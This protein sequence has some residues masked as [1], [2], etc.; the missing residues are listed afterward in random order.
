MTVVALLADTATL[1][2]EG[3]RLYRRHAGALLRFTF[4]PALTMALMV[5]GAVVYGET[6]RRA[7]P[8][9]G[10]FVA[11][12]LVCFPLLL[13]VT[14][15]VLRGV[16]TDQSLQARHLAAVGFYRFGRSLVLAVVV[17]PP[18]LVLGVVVARV[19]NPIVERNLGELR[20]W[21][22]FGLGMP[23]TFARFCIEV[24]ST[25]ETATTFTISTLALLLPYAAMLYLL[26]HRFRRLP[27]QSGAGW[28][29][30]TR[31][32][33]HTAIGTLL[34]NSVG[35]CILFSIASLMRYLSPPEEVGFAALFVLLLLWLWLLSPPLPILIALLYRRNRAALGDD[36]ERRVQEWA[37]TE[38]QQ[39]A[40]RQQPLAAEG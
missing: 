35:F 16:E 25:I 14:L 13:F 5:T 32:I 11:G 6:I 1:L 29:S 8:W 30:A 19:L 33:W 2:D 37:Q 23:R 27:K 17:M 20:Y 18:M 38:Q 4:W 31:T 24:L 3:L 21:L 40:I 9:W 15:G 22:S 7:G 36:L 10:S 12:L 34:I 39:Q 28:L 26:Q